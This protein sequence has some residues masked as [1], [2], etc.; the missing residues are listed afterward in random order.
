MSLARNSKALD[1]KGKVVLCI[2][3]R[4]LELAP[5]AQ[6]SEGTGVTGIPA[7]SLTGE[8]RPAILD[9]NGG[10][11]IDAV[12]FF[13]YLFY[14]FFARQCRRSVA[15]HAAKCHSATVRSGCCSRGLMT[16]ETVAAASAARLLFV[17]VV[18]QLAELNEPGPD[19]GP[20]H[21]SP[22]ISLC[23]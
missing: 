16:A 1:E 10:I 2:A 15:V 11:K 14:L 6:G 17:V 8:R 3:T 22:V 23:V 19:P 5:V 9:C 20:T 4:R 21:L 7:S 13:F 12:S 18:G